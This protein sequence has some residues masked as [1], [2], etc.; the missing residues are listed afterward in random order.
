[1]CTSK[2]WLVSEVVHNVPQFERPQCSIQAK[3]SSL[4]ADL[5]KQQGFQQ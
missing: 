1:M 4:F 3:T 5:T 2:Q